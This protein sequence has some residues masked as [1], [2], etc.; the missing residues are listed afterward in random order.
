[1]IFYVWTLCAIYR[2]ISVLEFINIVKLKIPKYGIK[3]LELAIKNKT[4]FEIIKSTEIPKV[5]IDEPFMIPMNK[6]LGAFDL[7]EC[8]KQ[9][10]QPQELLIDI[11]QANV[12]FC[13]NCLLENYKND[14]YNYYQIQTVKEA[15]NDVYQE[16]GVKS[17]F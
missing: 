2:K 10:K 6:T 4:F 7:K 15:I 9:K 11:K 1:M 5:K 13:F 12:T 16:K 14:V 17:H 3:A 8:F